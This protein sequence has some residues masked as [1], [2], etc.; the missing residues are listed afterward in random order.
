MS[1]ILVDAESVTPIRVRCDALAAGQPETLQ[2]A[3]TG[4]VIDLDVSLKAAELFGIG[5]GVHDQTP[6]EARWTAFSMRW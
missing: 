6:V 1:A 2:N 3:A 5:E 4:N